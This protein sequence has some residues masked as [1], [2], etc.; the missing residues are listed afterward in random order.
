MPVKKGLVEENVSTKV[1]AALSTA[2]GR[3]IS[4][5]DDLTYAEYETEL[6]EAMLKVHPDRGGDEETFKILSEER[7]RIRKRN[8]EIVPKEK[9]TTISGAKLLPGTTFRPDDIKPADVDKDTSD[10]STVNIADRL[11]N[12]ADA[13]GVIGGLFKLELKALQD[14]EAQDR[15]DKAEQ[16][17]KAR[18]AE[19][20]AKKATK[21]K[22]DSKLKMPKL[23]FFDTLKK[24]FLNVAAGAATLKLVEWFKNPANRDKVLAFTNFLKDNAKAIF[25]TLAALVAL[26]I[27]GSLG[28]I[29]VVLKGLGVILSSPW[30]WAFLA[31]FGIGKMLK[32]D[33]ISE[34]LAEADRV[35]YEK[36]IEEGVD[37]KKALSLV[38]SLIH[39]RRCRRST[40]CRSRWSPYH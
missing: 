28:G 7:D 8:S 25:V 11:N 31:L 5:V 3:E 19:L 10:S 24:F 35:K 13:L 21:P 1:L 39:I 33:K 23:G 17:K 16:D 38:L 9:K 32:M 30:F 20:E 22:K 14:K 34:N 36:L 26:N 4:F 15:K 27:A 37:P 2:F 6:R 40:L 29:L 18:E 12:I